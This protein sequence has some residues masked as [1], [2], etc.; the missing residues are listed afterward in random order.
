MELVGGVAWTSICLNAPGDPNVWPQL[1]TA[2]WG[3]S[4]GGS[5]VN[6]FSRAQLRKYSSLATSRS[7]NYWFPFQSPPK[8]EIHSSARSWV[9]PV[10]GVTHLIGLFAGPALFYLV[11]LGL[12]ADTVLVVRFLPE[13]KRKKHGLT[14]RK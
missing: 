3:L 8:I 6:H 4:D 14:H 10:G 2:V 11:E 7:H 9:L 12:T 1:R 13:K 5:T